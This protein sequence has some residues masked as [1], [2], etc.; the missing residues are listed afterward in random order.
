MSRLAI[1]AALLGAL[2]TSVPLAAQQTP[3]SPQV[4]AITRQAAAAYTRRDYAAALTLA[5]QGCAAG[6]KEA[7]FTK[8]LTLLTAPKSD[9]DKQLGVS[10]LADVCRRKFGEACDYAGQLTA[11]GTGQPAGMIP[12]EERR[13]R[14]AAN[15]I[16]F[17]RQGCALNRKI[18]CSKMAIYYYIG[19]PDGAPN[20]AAVDFKM[21][22][23]L[24]ERAVAAGAGADMQ[25]TVE[26]LRLLTAPLSTTADAVQRGKA[27]ERI[28]SEQMFAPTKAPATAREAAKAACLA[29][30]AE[31]CRVH[32]D[33]K[34]ARSISGY[35]SEGHEP[36]YAHDQYTRLCAQKVQSACFGLAVLYQT[37]KRVFHATAPVPVSFRTSCERGVADACVRWGV[38]IEKGPGDGLR[39]A[40]IVYADACARG[41]ALA[42]DAAG[43]AFSTRDVRQPGTPGWVARDAKEADRFF[44]EAKRLVPQYPLHLALI[45][46]GS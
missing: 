18:S 17:F 26:A 46:L 32:A 41:S 28:W 29:G 24:A 34:V 43:K 31:A 15:A 9:A 25:Q 13:A 11:S 30:A 33:T 19:G 37:D 35:P 10:I 36:Y 3:E 1:M 38:E 21:A 27:V 22:L 6:M 44:R 2:L 7:C 39:R 42:C 16:P 8:A 40:R 14:N 5:E 23:Q 4:L 12:Y 45:G 20:P